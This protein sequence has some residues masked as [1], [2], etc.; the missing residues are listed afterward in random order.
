MSAIRKPANQHR[1][2]IDVGRGERRDCGEQD[3]YELLGD[4]TVIS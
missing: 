1:E 4:Q 3:L 2:I